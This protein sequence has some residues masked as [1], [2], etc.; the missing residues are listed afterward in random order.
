MSKLEDERQYVI[1]DK[2]TKGLWAS[3]VY[4]SVSGAKTSYWHASTDRIN[5]RYTKTKFDDQDNYEIVKV[6]LVPID[7]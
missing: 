5:G 2:V 7:E 3:E 6:K 4:L 1:V